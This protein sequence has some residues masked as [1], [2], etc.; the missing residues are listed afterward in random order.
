MKYQV[1]GDSDTP[2]VEFRMN[3]GESLMIERGS[4]AY[5][6]G[7]DLQGKLNSHGG[8]LGAIGRSLAGGESMFITQANATMDDAVLG[9]APAVPGQISKLSVGQRQYR[10]NT[11]AFLACA[12]SVTYNIVAQ[13]LSRAIFGGTGGLFVMETS[14]S[15]DILINSFGSLITLDVTPDKPLVIDNDHVVA[16]D[17]G[18]NYNI[19]IASGV[20][21][22]TTGEG[23]VNRFTGNGQVIIQTRNIRSLAGE[24]SKYISSGN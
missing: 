11:G 6:Y 23:L 16:W 5:M 24:L 3:A 12:P 19:E 15:G 21:G 1:L 9:I 18:L 10:L 14:G 2:I 7:I 13:K 8:L 17:A 4:M 22:F 20:F